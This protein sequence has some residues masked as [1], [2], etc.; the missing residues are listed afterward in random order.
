MNGT[1]IPRR[2]PLAVRRAKLP[3]VIQDAPGEPFISDLLKANCDLWAG[4]LGAAFVSD[5]GPIQDFGC[6]TV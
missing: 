2:L 6:L 4:T 1:E 3:T 5:W